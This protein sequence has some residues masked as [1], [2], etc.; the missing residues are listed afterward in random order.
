MEE[1]T[2]D[3]AQETGAA[4]PKEV[5]PE[6]QQPEPSSQQ[7]SQNGEPS[8][9][10]SAGKFDSYEP[11]PVNLTNLLEAGAHFGHQTHRW[12]PKMLPFIFGE[13]NNVHIINL[14]LT[15]IHWEKAK[16][17]LEDIGKRGGSLLFVGTKPQAKKLVEEAAERIG[18][19]SVSQR[20]LGGTLSNFETIKR[21]IA[22][23][24]SLEDLLEQAR[25]EESG[26][27]LNKKER[28][29]ITRELEK[30]E[31]NLGGIRHMKHLPACLFVVDIARESIAVKEARKLHIPVVALVDTN[32][33]PNEVDYAVPCNDDATRTLRLFINAAADAFAEGRESFLARAGKEDA[34]QAQS[35]EA[36][37]LKKSTQ[38]GE[39]AEASEPAAAASPA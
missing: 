32:V 18:M 28:L 35:E 14:D 20:W 11:V 25:D 36:A 30:L 9:Y 3:K 7:P 17:F 15:L 31:S 2:E 13:K 10:S 27:K 24:R 16:K 6:K 19:F 5:A 26:V 34:D 33:D 23:I 21:S 4:A 37:E 29:G 38:K 39:S 12:N 1:T 22:R 8:S